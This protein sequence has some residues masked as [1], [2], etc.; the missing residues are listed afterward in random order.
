M[1]YAP[2]TEPHG[3][4]YEEESLHG[5]IRAA[6]N[7]GRNHMPENTPL[8]PDPQ[9]HAPIPPAPLATVSLAEIEASAE[10]FVSPKPD[11]EKESEK[12]FEENLEAAAQ[13]ANP[14]NSTLD[15]MEK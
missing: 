12:S 10:M 14:G 11:P 3:R 9:P 8:I 4:S 2:G 6:I 15:A 1:S 7:F 13:A 5:S